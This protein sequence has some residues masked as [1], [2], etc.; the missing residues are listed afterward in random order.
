MK[1][2]LSSKLSSESG[3]SL[4]ESALALA[5]LGLIIAGVWIVSGSAFGSNKKNRLAEQVIASVETIRSYSRNVDMGATVLNTQNIWDLGLLPTDVR[6]G[7]TF[8]N[9]YGGS[10]GAALSR[11]NLYITLTDVPSEACV[12]LIYSRLGGSAE[13]AENLGFI[14]YAPTTTE[15]PTSSNFSFNAVTNSCSGSTDLLLAFQP[16]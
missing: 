10:F 5:I 15:G 13:A 7:G 9:I 6:R 2:R 11:T 4:L 1:F 14:G 8:R 3:L 16:R 12:D